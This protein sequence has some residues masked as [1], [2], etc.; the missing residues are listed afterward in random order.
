M[1]LTQ[2]LELEN[3]LSKKIEKIEESFLTES[4]KLTYEQALASE[5][6]LSEKLKEQSEAFKISMENEL[7]DQQTKLREQYEAGTLFDVKL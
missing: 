5:K 7:K 6:L 2:R 4:L 3:E 1:L